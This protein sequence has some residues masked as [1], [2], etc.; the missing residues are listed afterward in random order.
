M[1][2]REVLRKELDES[3]EF[4]LILTELKAA[5]VDVLTEYASRNKKDVSYIDN[6]L[7]VTSKNIDFKS[8]LLKLIKKE[9]IENEH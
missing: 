8:E 1:S 7:V 6:I 5:A 3:P 2:S 4:D 9:E